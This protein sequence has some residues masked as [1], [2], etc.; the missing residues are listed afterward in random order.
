MEYIY[1]LIES[2]RT[3]SWIVVVGYIASLF[4]AI[5]FYM[6]TIIPLR[7]FA[8]CSNIF[9]ITYGF[10]GGLGP[11]FFLH[12]FLFPLNVVR[13]VQMKKLIAKVKAASQGEYSLDSL[14]PF[15]TKRNMAEGEVLFKKGS[16]APE[17]FY[18]QKGKVYLE[19]IG[20]TVTEGN[21]IGE[22]GIFSPYKT[23]TATAMCVEDGQLMTIHEST[24]TQLY[25]QNPTF[26]YYLIQ[27]IIKR[28]I[29]N[30]DREHS[31]LKH[32]P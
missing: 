24:I 31:S 22:I 9:F 5:T 8:I 7:I 11:V 26:G 30:Y 10:F 1:N 32:E 25:Y 13:L 19:E 16:P 20:Q 15:M 2:F 3:I 17:I 21:I 6:K 27:L 14:V 18:I 28:F 12:V 29:E 23:R 4:T